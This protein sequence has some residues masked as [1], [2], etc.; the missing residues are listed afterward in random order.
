MAVTN[1]YHQTYY[2]DIWT[3]TLSKYHVERPQPGKSNFLST[4]NNRLEHLIC[5]G[6]CYRKSKLTQETTAWTLNSNCAIPLFLFAPCTMYI[7]VICTSQTC[8]FIFGKLFLNLLSLQAHTKQWQDDQPN[9]G[10]HLVVEVEVRLTSFLFENRRGKEMK[11]WHSI[12]DTLSSSVLGDDNDS[13]GMLFDH[14]Y[15]TK[16]KTFSV[17]H[18]NYHAGFRWYMEVKWKSQYKTSMVG[19]FA[20]RRSQC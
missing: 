7:N 14:Q 5:L 9:D 10:G 1:W 6:D 4:Y 18:E 20:F 17:C 8:I 12:I 2:Q 19:K 3:L 16:F 11:S 13:G 15:F